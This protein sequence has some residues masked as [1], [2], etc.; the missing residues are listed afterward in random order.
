GTEGYLIIGHTVGWKQFK[1]NGDVVAERT[2]RAD[3]QAHH[4]DFI[5]CVQGKRPRTA[6]DI[7][8]GVDSA[9]IVHLANIAA[10]TQTVVEYHH[11]R[12]EVTNNTA[13]N[14][15]VKRKYH[16]GHWAIPSGLEL[17]GE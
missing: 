14:A 10:R 17:S 3:L 11:E 5:E 8:A 6:A 9:S 15:L 1:P 12:G 2:G 7:Q 13:A 16:P 4:T